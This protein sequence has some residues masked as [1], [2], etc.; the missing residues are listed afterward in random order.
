[1]EKKQSRSRFIIILAIFITV[2]NLLIYNDIASFWDFGE[3]DL[4]SFIPSKALEGAQTIAPL[5]NKLLDLIYNQTLLSSIFLRLPATLA[6]LMTLGGLYFLGRRI[7]GEPAARM[8]TLVGACSFL[9]LF[10]GKLV[11]VD[12]WLIAAQTFQILGLIYYLKQPQI[13]WSFRSNLPFFLGCYLAPIPM[14]LWTG[15]ILLFYGA[16]HKNGKNILK[17]IFSIPVVLTVIIV[18]LSGGLTWET[19]GLLMVWPEGR[20]GNFF[21]YNVLAY[22]PWLA[23]LPAAL[24]DV[25]KKLRKREELAIIYSGWL[26]GALVAGTGVLQM[27]LALMIGRH[28]LF[29]FQKNY[30]YRSTVRSLVVTH[31]IFS[32][33]GLFAFIMLAGYNQFGGAGYR[34]AIAVAIAYWGGSLVSVT[35]IFSDRQGR[36]VGSLTVAAMIGFL[37]FWLNGMPLLESRRGWNRIMVE[38]ATSYRSPDTKQLLFFTEEPSLLPSGTNIYAQAAK[39]KTEGLPV[40]QISTAKRNTNDLVVLPKSSFLKIN[41]TPIILRDSVS[42]YS[43][44]FEEPVKYY[45]GKWR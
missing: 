2:V 31:F 30:P 1:M 5:P 26:L 14:F 21:M 24:W 7:F 28:V 12:A 32:F 40:K 41:P 27:V 10:F 42:M 13:E 36:L 43:G 18:I 4:L 16:F 45:I 23:F 44:I 20:V 35:A 15:A 37:M 25:F 19:P 17:P 3:V 8:A 38:K 6:I 22:L 33:F 11:G 34:A 29:Y 9:L 39:I